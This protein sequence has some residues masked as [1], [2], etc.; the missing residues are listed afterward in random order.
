M[1]AG[2]ET[3]PPL[4]TRPLRLD[5]STSPVVVRQSLGWMVA[6]SH[7]HYDMQ[8]TTGCSPPDGFLP[9]AS[10][11]IGRHEIEASFLQ[12]I[13]HPLVE[14]DALIDGRNVER[15]ARLE[16]SNRD[17]DALD[18]LPTQHC[19]LPFV[20]LHGTGKVQHEGLATVKTHTDPLATAARSMEGHEAQIEASVGLG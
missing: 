20:R 4:P 17:G 9:A 14:T 5:D 13:Y 1:Q 6:D 15:V 19:P 18:K 7:I 16:T 12:E 10:P 2:L 11:L 3:A 8:A